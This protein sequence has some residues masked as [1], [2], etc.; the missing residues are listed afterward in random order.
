MPTEVRLPQYGMTMHEATL[1]DWLKQ[2]GEPVEEGEPLV[3]FETD[4]MTVDIPAP[5]SGKLVRVD[6]QP[7]DTVP[8]LAII[9]LID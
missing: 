5:A 3:A 2:L 7:G 4:K 8:V 9:G 6:V 1:L